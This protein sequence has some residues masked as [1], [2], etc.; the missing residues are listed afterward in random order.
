MT[1]QWLL[2]SEVGLCPCGCI[3]TRRGFNPASEPVLDDKGE[4]IVT[5]RR[6]SD[7][8]GRVLQTAKG[9]EATYTFVPDDLYVRAVNGPTGAWFR[10]TQE[11][12]EGHIR[13]GG[14]E[15]EVMFD[16]VDHG[17]D[18]QIDAAYRSKYRR[19]AP[20]IVDSVLTPEARAATL[21][22]VPR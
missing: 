9:T 22:L 13:S 5:T 1:P 11:R 20:S 3:G 2:R 15:K 10:G 17:L 7:D 19:Y 12:H 16:E 21:E 14:V 4:P 6:Y 18:D 8:V